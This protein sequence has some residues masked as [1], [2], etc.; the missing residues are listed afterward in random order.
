MKT[1][2]S[3]VFE[4]FYNTRSFRRKIMKTLYILRHAKSDWNNAAL[5]DFERP[6]NERG[7]KIAPLMGKLMKERNFTPQLIISS[8]A[9]RAKQT[10]ELIKENA[11]IESEIK[12]DSRIYEAHPQTLLKIVSEIDDAND[13]ALIVGHNPGFENL[14]R[15]LTAKIEP[16]PTAALAIVDLNINHWNQTSSATGTLRDLLRPKEL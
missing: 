3:F 6:L 16:M 5:S 2:S 12:F 4:K 1:R 10:A 13:S 14:V 9:V 8:P 15:I 7:R 11:R